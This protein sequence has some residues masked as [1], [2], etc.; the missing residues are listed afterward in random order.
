[1]SEQGTNLIATVLFKKGDLE[2]GGACGKR[3]EG[4]EK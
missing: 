4:L 1:M 3:G 2:G